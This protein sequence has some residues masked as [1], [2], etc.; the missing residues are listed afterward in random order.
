MSFLPFVI[1]GLVNGVVVGVAAGLVARAI[2]PP[3][4]QTMRF[5]DAAL[6][7]MLGSIAGSIVVTALSFQD[8][9]LASGPSSLLYSVVG[10]ALAIGLVGY[11]GSHRAR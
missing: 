1:I 7:G 5:R 11:S 8:G 3:G 4:A 9:Y 10:A 2:A 6:L